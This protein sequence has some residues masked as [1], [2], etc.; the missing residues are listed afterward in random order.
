[1]TGKAVFGGNHV[2]G[3]KE[4]DGMFTQKKRKISKGMFRFFSGRGDED[5]GFF[6]FSEKEGKNKSFRRTVK[7]AD[8]RC[9]VIPAHPL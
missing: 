1:M 6:R 7:A 8:I 4:T 2:P 3:R 9:P 5:K